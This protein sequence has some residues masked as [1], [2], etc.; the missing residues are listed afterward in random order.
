M[1]Y[2]NVNCQCT[3]AK[4]CWCDNNVKILGDQ[5][6]ISVEA[7]SNS[8]QKVRLVRKGKEDEVVYQEENQWFHEV[9]ALVKLV[10]EKD[11]ERC[12]RQ[13]ENTL[14]VVRVLEEARKS[15]GLQFGKV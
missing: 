13:L 2:K 4:D 10:E 14:T 15:A 8:C 9:Q 7:A 3:G 12:Y 11:Y 1:Q 6:Y 5:G